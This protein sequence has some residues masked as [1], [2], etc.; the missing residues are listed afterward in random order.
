MNTTQTQLTINGLEH[1]ICY[2]EAKGLSLC[3][4][5]Y[6]EFAIGECIMEGGIGFNPNSGYTYIALENGISIC[7][8]MGRSVEYIVCHPETS[9]EIFCETYEDAE[10]IFID[11]NESL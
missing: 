11:Y 9:D 2:C 8:M 4:A 1:N 6:S 5:A 10:Q 7:S 3:F